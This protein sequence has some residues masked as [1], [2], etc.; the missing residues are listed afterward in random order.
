[1]ADAPAWYDWRMMSTRID[2]VA[3]HCRLLAAEG[4]TVIGGPTKDSQVHGRYL[5]QVIAA[6]PDLIL[7]IG[8]D[9]FAKYLDAPYDGLRG[10]PRRRHPAGCA[11]SRCATA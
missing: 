2:W 4:V 11:W 6:Q 8:S 5:D 9:L 10:V 1:M 3:E 7:D